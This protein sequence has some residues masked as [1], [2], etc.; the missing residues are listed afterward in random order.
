MDRYKYTVCPMDGLGFASAS[1]PLSREVQG[2]RALRVLQAYD[3][4]YRKDD[5]RVAD[6]QR[7]SVD[8][9]DDPKD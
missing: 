2:A 8:F 7:F 6:S 9:I 1:C 3:W 4:A 5:P